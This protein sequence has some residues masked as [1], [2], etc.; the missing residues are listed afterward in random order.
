M[1]VAGRFINSN[2][3]ASDSNDARLQAPSQL[4]WQVLPV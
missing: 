3:K 2:L 4:M 1:A